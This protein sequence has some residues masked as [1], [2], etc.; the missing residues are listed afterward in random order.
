VLLCKQPRERNLS[1]RR[2]FPLSHLVEQVHQGLICLQSLRRKA[3]Q[4]A[5]EVCAVELRVLLNFA[6]Q[7]PLPSGL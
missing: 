6:G 4:D 3:W 2:F 1:W 5:S 7:D